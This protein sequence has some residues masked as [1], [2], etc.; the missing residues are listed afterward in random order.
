MTPRKLNPRTA[1]P[2]RPRG[3]CRIGPGVGWSFWPPVPRMRVTSAAAPARRAV[4]HPQLPSR[5]IP[6]S[7]VKVT[8]SIGLSPSEHMAALART[9]PAPRSRSRSVSVGSPGP[10]SRG[11]A[12]PSGI[13]AMFM[14]EVGSRDVLAALT[15][16]RRGDRRAPARQRHP[17]VPA[18]SPTSCS[19][20][21]GATVQERSSGQA[22]SWASAPVRRC[23]APSTG[24][25]RPWRCSGRPTPARQPRRPGRAVPARPRPAG[26]RRRSGSRPLRSE[27]D[28]S[29]GRRPPTGCS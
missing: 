27:G 17:A 21:A 7:V 18:R 5:R 24:S 11:S 10:A 25:G 16:T 23:G 1:S 22:R 14:P 2:R 13:G 19:R 6:S 20:E 29:R 28:A 12:S 26:R 4:G 3:R 15:G 8:G 9:H